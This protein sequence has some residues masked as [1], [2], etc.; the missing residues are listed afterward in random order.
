MSQRIIIFI[1][2]LFVLACD[3]QDAQPDRKPP[4]THVWQ[5]QV[6]TIDKAR[7]VQQTVNDQAD[8]Q[9]QQ[10]DDQTR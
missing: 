1:T 6:K 5:D 4:Q 7:A 10:I 8:A 2:A 3:R 9:K